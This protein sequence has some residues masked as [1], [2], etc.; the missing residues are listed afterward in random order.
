MLDH[1]QSMTVSR[2]CIAYQQN[3]E[4]RRHCNVNWKPTRENH[5]KLQICYLIWHHHWRNHYS[6]DII[7]VTR[8]STNLYLYYCIKILQHGMNTKNMKFVQNYKFLKIF[9]CFQQNSHCRTSESCRILKICLNMLNR[10]KLKVAKTQP[11]PVYTFWN[12]SKSL[13]G[14]VVLKRE[15]WNTWASDAWYPLKH[16]WWGFFAKTVNHLLFPQRRS[17]IDI[18]HGL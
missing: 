4:K 18:W 9:R 11:K 5:A 10:Y 1:P 14:R 3:E 2:H 12:F 16:I 7:R 6:Y 15:N 17:I 8:S 13:S